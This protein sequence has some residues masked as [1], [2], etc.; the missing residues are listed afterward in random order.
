LGYL[1]IKLGRFSKAQQ[2]CEIMLDQ[3]ADHAKEA[4]I[5]LRLE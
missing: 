5:Y 3:K 4:E 2:I 1:L